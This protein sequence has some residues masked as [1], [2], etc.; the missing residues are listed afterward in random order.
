ML[1]REMLTLGI[2]KSL[3][4]EQEVALGDIDLS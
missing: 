4:K 1:S 3:P 2:L